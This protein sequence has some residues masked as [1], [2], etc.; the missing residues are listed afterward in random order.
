MVKVL[1]QI[2]NDWGEF[3]FSHMTIKT[4]QEIIQRLPKEQRTP[5]VFL[6]HIIEKPRLTLWEWQ[7]KV[8][9]AILN[10]IYL[11]VTEALRKYREDKQKLEIVFKEINLLPLKYPN[12]YDIFEKELNRLV[13]KRDR[14]LEKVK[15][16]EDEEGT[17]TFSSAD[18][19][20]ISKNRNLYI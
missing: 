2:G 6:H 1:I 5:S 12:D 15:N 4:T 3:Y 9:I 20:K 13:A 19:N 18:I 17:I 7:N 8:P 10:S 16:I 14:L 11:C